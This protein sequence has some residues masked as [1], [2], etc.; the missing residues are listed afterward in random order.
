M[1]IVRSLN[2]IPDDRSKR[3]RRI[4]EFENAESIELDMEVAYYQGMLPGAEVSADVIKNAI[5]ADRLKCAETEALRLLARKD[6]TESGL[7]KKLMAGG[8]TEEHANPIVERC[9]EWGYLD[10]S[11]FAERLIADCVNLRKLGPVRV[12]SELRRR[13]VPDEIAE[14]ALDTASET[15]EAPVDQALRALAGKRRTYARLDPDVAHRRMY[16]FL[17]RR[18]FTSDIIRNAVDQFTTSLREDT[19]T[20]DES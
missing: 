4:I 16:G 12:R 5:Q 11:K 14:A 10:D 20:S 15:A 2:E 9:L 7:L 6:Y 18:G 17:Q 1:P 3:R 13:G 19:D 8:H